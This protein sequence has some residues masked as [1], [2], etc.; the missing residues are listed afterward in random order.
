MDDKDAATE[1]SN[2]IMG[3]LYAIANKK[4]SDITETGVKGD[5]L[6]LLI[7]CF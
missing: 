1:A 5:D 6:A 3:P 7:R 2:W 4:G